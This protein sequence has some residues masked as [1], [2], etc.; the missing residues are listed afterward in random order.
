[1]F[2]D[3]G[4]CERKLVSGVGKAQ[5]LG[6][7]DK[8]AQPMKGRIGVHSIDYKRITKTMSQAFIS[9][10][11][12]NGKTQKNGG[13]LLP[14]WESIMSAPFITFSRRLR[15]TPFTSRVL[16]GGAQSF[17]VY[18][19]MLLASWFRGVEAD[20]WHLCQH[21]QVWDVSC[22]R[23]VQIKGPDAYQ[24]VQWMTPRDLSKAQSDQCFYVPLCDEQGR[25]INDPIA[26]HVA[27][28]T[29]WLSIADSDVL[30]WAKGLATG[31]GLDVE[32]TEPEVWPIAVQGPKADALMARVFGEEVKD[33]RFFR[34]RRLHYRGH[35]FI[36][37]RSGWSHQGG[38]EI[39]VDDASLGQVLWDELFEQGV[40]LHVG[41][42]CPNNIERMEAG[43]LSYGNDMDSAMT[44]LQ[45]GLDKY[46]HLDRDLPSLSVAA[47]AEQKRNGVP[48]RLMGVV[49]PDLPPQSGG[50]TLQIDGKTAAEITSHCYSARY[51]AWLAFALISREQISA[52]QTGKAALQLKSDHGVST[53]QLCDLPFQLDRMGLAHRQCHVDSFSTV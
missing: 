21:V 38:F 8:A 25:L 23:Q 30:L 24:L 42:G 33:I 4:L 2:A 6:S 13:I 28:D 44:P 41:H 46:C 5:S 10:F 7:N 43:L 26:I 34:Y 48:S 29:W 1:M 15:E 14:A 27:A 39:Y 19:H 35:D 49:V 45:C 16:A 51:H 11:A 17:T 12:R 53:A 9:S 20:Y 22:E 3:G 50:F 31:Q 52:V 37:A 32:I 40:D 36:V 47:L 18:N